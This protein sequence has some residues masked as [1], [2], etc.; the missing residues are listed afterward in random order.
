LALALA[1]GA[2]APAAAP[3]AALAAPAAPEPAVAVVQRQVDAYNAHDLDAFAGTYAADVI[4]QRR[5]EV[6]L[7]GIASLRERYGRTF[8]KFPNLRVRIVERRLEGDRLV[9]DHEV[10]SG[11]PPEKGDAWDLGWVTYEVDRGLI[12]RVYLP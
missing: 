4:I 6:Y 10:A 2:C 5:G 9:L 3:P 8:A 7:S 11:G 1:L 12:R